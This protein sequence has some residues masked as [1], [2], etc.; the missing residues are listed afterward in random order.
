MER[1]DLPAKME[2]KPMVYRKE[3]KA[4]VLAHSTYMGYEFAIISLG[5]HPCAYIG[6][7]EGHRLYGKPYRHSAFE[8]FPV[9]CGL[10][11]SQKGVRGLMQDKWV[12]GWDYAHTC[13]YMPIPCMDEGRRWTTDEIFE[14]V[15]A[16]IEAVI[17][18]D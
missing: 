9:H 13:D 7:P 10:T 17:K 1:L 16:A 5:T 14:E 11:Y 12:L 8:D 15:R 18:E 2:I 3:R 6:I 4:E